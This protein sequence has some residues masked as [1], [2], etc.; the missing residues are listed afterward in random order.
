MGGGIQQLL[1]GGIGTGLHGGGQEAEG[2][3]EVAG[4]EWS[5]PKKRGKSRVTRFD[6]VYTSSGAMERKLN[7]EVSPL[8]PCQA[9]RLPDSSVRICSPVWL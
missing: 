4:D 3:E 8:R 9:G 7:I 6:N 2:D 1:D 5:S